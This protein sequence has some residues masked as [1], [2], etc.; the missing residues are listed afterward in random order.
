MSSTYVDQIRGYP[1]KHHC[2]HHGERF[3]FKKKGKFWTCPAYHECGYS[4][5]SRRLVGEVTYLWIRQTR[6][7][8]AWVKLLQDRT[9]ACTE[10]LSPEDAV[11]AG[12]AGDPTALTAL[13]GP[14]RTVPVPLVSVTT[15]AGP[16]AP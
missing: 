13:L 3:R 12:I 5:G 4:I 1:E 2:P 14:L 15:T 10:L 9:R 7:G 8:R 11:A 6:R 16:L